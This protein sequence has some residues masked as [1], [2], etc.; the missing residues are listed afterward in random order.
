METRELERSER[1][2]N[3]ETRWILGSAIAVALIAALLMRILVDLA[4]GAYLL[5]GLFTFL[6]VMSFAW[7]AIIIRN[8]MWKDTKYFL[9]QD[10]ILV[11]R[12]RGFIGSGVTQ[13]V[14]LYESILS[15]SFQQDYFGKKYGYGDI[16]IS[17]PKLKE[18]LVLKSVVEPSQQLPHIKAQL[19]QRTDRPR[20]LVT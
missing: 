16:N 12:P 4:F 20:A 2:F 13:D 8:K 14:Y 6:I 11:T 18:T 9:G 10:A 17:I 1:A 19:N 5:S 15:L 7:L 3:I